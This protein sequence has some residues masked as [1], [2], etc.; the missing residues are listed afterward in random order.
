MFLSRPEML[1]VAG[2]FSRFIS[3]WNFKVLRTLISPAV[4]QILV[5]ATQTEAPDIGNATKSPSNLTFLL[6]ILAG[7]GTFALAYDHTKRRIV[8][9]L[10]K[11]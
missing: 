8:E 9:G 1:Y 7:T 5:E 6:H 3:P 10:S 11:F 4:Y 2:A